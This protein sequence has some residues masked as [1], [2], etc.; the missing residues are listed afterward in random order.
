MLP[1]IKEY[2]DDNHTL[3][4]GIQWDEG[5][6]TPSAIE[7]TG[8]L[9]S[10][11]VAS[12]PDDSIMPIHAAMRRC[13]VDDSGN[14]VYYLNPTNSTKK[15]DGGA[16]VLTGADG[17]VMVEIPKFY[18]RYAYA[19]TVHTW[20]ISF[21]P[22]AGFILHP[23]FNKDGA[24]V[25]FRYIGAYEGTLYDTSES[26]YVNGLYLLTSASYKMTFTMLTTRF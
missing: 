1:A 6:T 22:L 23:A 21:E 12:K 19:G 2:V 11:V 18:Y 25:D 7:R 14:V 13:V 17:Q 20:D 15:Q 3:Y 16:S 5:T 4:Y 9:E 8:A 10:V 24:V 26:K